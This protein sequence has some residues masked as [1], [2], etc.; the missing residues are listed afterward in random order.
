MLENSFSRVREL[1]FKVFVSPSTQDAVAV[2]Q[3]SFAGSSPAGSCWS[4]GRIV[5]LSLDKSGWRVIQDRILQLQHH[6]AFEEI[7]VIDLDDGGFRELIVDADWG[8]A[9]NIGSSLLIYSLREGQLEMA[10]RHKSLHR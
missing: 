1:Q 3:Y 9:G 7:R 8:G 2:L 4:V 5:R 10:S 6:S